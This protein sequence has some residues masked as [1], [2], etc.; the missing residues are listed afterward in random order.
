M[1][2]R[3]SATYSV[4]SYVYSKYGDSNTALAELVKA[5]YNYGVSAENYVG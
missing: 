5:T 2:E 4:N 1:L 3:Q